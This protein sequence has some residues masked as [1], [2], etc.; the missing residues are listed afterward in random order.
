[1]P[2]SSLSFSKTNS[3]PTAKSYLATWE[4]RRKI[5]LFRPA[6]ALCSNFAQFPGSLSLRPESTDFCAKRL[7]NFEFA[8]SLPWMALIRRS[9]SAAPRFRIHKWRTATRESRSKW[10]WPFPLGKLV[11]FCK[12]W[13]F[14]FRNIKENDPDAGTDPC[15]SFLKPC[16]T[17]RT[18]LFLAKCKQFLRSRQNVFLKQKSLKCW[19]V[20]SWK[21]FLNCLIFLVWQATSNCTSLICFCRLHCFN[22]RRPCIL[23]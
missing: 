4:V 14:I 15:K 20:F 17:L 23:H 21:Y 13:R 3:P 9:P 18:L 1:M 22:Q 19:L 10:C 7:G 12:K 8:A 5:A 6:V 16:A 2:I 11:Y